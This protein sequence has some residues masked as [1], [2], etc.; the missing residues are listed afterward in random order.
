MADD[1]DSVTYIVSEV[2]DA[3]FELISL[4]AEKSSWKGRRFL[5][6]THWEY[7]N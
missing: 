4:I 7:H 3:Y 2:K 1:G 5:M 6:P